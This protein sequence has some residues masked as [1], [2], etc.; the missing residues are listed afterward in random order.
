MG[1]LPELAR[2][3][4][5]PPAENPFGPLPEPADAQTPALPPEDVD[6]GP[7]FFGGEDPAFA[8]TLVLPSLGLEAPATSDR[9]QTASQER[10]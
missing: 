9:Y 10:S 6:Q 4:A 3:P 2:E 8:A 5:E 7:D 1:L